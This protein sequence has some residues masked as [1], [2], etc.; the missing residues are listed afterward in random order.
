M[1][2]MCHTKLVYTV[3]KLLP[4]TFRPILCEIGLR[5]PIQK[6]NCHRI[7]PHSF[8]IRFSTN[9]NITI[10]RIEYI[11]HAREL[12]GNPSIATW[13]EGT[14]ETRWDTIRCRL[15]KV[16]HMPSN[17]PIGHKLARQRLNR[18][19]TGTRTRWTVTISIV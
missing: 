16:V 19:R 17:K 5:I 10:I 18:V 9:A 4:S 1:R 15:R 6:C 7:I 2:Y 3:N 13:V 11:V 12:V 8:T 14:W